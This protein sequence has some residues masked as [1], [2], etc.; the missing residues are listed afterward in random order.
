MKPAAVLLAVALLAEVLLVGVVAIT[1]A[2]DIVL[3]LARRCGVY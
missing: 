2:G 1:V 3:S